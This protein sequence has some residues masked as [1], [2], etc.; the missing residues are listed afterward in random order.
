MSGKERLWERPGK[1][2]WRAKGGVDV[3]STDQM[4]TWEWDIIHGMG[5][6][7]KA[8]ACNLLDIGT[9]MY[10]PMQRE[11]KGRRE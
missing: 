4:R 2:C 6:G 5:T 1:T 3:R 8:T 7:H 10:I 11:G 9:Y